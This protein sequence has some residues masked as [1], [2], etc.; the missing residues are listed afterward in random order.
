MLMF[1]IRIACL[2]GALQSGGD[3]VASVIQ[4]NKADT[5]LADC[6][7][8]LG[9]H[10]SALQ[11]CA[12]EE[13]AADP[14]SCRCHCPKCGPTVDLS[15][16]PRCSYPPPFAVA[17]P[18]I[19]YAPHP[20]VPPEQ[21]APAMPTLP[22]ISSL[23]QCHD[24]EKELLLAL[25][26]QGCKKRLS[27]LGRQLRGI[28]PGGGVQCNCHCPPCN[29]G[30][31]PAPMCWPP[32]PSTT[33]PAW[34]T[35][36]SKGVPGVAPVV[37]PPPQLDGGKAKSVVWPPPRPL[38]KSDLFSS[39]L[40]PLPSNIDAPWKMFA[41]PEMPELPPV[42]ENFL[43]TLGPVVPYV[44][45]AAPSWVPTNGI[46]GTTGSAAAWSDNVGNAAS[47]VSDQVGNAASSV[48]DAI[49]R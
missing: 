27:W 3:A 29:M 16:L 34:L 6:V 22:P 47:S 45:A 33:P 11:A 5:S 41:P 46:A 23:A 30:G 49:F 31:T 8:S 7:A 15:S 26:S 2:L 18:P 12:V 43:P 39:T 24:V 35:G 14:Q 37:W 9:R 20:T 25:N 21:P 40:A 28:Q 1:G 19:K 10:Q 17:P 42:G 38:Y 32:L 4:R 48:S 44:A 13:Q 36:A